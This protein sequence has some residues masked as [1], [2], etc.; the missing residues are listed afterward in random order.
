MLR[1]SGEF[2][3]G[4]LD[5]VL[6]DADLDRAVESGSIIHN[7]GDAHKRLRRM[8]ATE[9]AVRRMEAMRPRDVAR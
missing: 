9:F 1:D 7:D 5:H 8:L 2:P 3:V 6:P 4:V